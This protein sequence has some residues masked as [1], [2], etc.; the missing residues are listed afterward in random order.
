MNA[1]PNKLRAKVLSAYGYHAHASPA[2]AARRLLAH[3]G[4]KRLTVRRRAPPGAAL[5]R[6]SRAEGKAPLWAV[7]AAADWLS[8]RPTLRAEDAAAA[9]AAL[10]ICPLPE[11]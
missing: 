4:A 7:Q 8:Q 6:W 11:D 5:E 2:E 10:A 3:A 9:R 1:I